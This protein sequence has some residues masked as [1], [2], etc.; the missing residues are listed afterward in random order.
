MSQFEDSILAVLRV[1][2]DEF[3][4]TFQ[5]NANTI[6]YRIELKPIRINKMCKFI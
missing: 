3:Q 1:E 5:H 4:D 6:Q 2:D